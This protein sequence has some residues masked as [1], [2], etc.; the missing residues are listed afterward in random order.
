MPALGGLDWRIVLPSPN[1]WATTRHI[2]DA[3]QAINLWAL[4][5][6]GMVPVDLVDTGCGS[7]KVKYYITG[8]HHLG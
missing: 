5:A 7:Q 2:P 1:F 6:G 8:T 4:W 3:G